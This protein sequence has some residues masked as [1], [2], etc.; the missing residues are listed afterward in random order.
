VAIQ[1]PDTVAAPTELFRPGIVGG[2]VDAGIGQQYDVSRDG[3]F[4]VNTVV[5]DAA[6]APIT[7]VQHWHPPT[8]AR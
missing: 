6:S 7:L 2:G 1:L 5:G 8:E 4:L 3:R